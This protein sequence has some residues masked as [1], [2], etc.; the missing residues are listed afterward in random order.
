MGRAGTMANAV[1]HQ[2]LPK[3]LPAEWHAAHHVNIS[4]AKREEASAERLRAECERLRRETD[5]TTA[6]MQ[7]T[8]L[9]KFTQRIRD[10]AFWKQELE[11]MLSEN[12]QETE[13]ILGEKKK[14]EDTLLATQ[15]PLDVTNACL[16]FRTQREQIDLVHDAV[17]IQLIK[18]FW[19]LHG[20]LTC[21]MTLLSHATHTFSTHTCTQCPHR[22]WRS[23]KECRLCFRKRLTR[24]WTKLGK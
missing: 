24:Q 9:H 18:V 7:Q 8:N 22:R 12:V 6:R 10:I 16:E 3:C 21:A 14:L 13:L 20:S 1:H 23:C 5:A 17:E 15:F 2:P 19:E 11:T 4:T